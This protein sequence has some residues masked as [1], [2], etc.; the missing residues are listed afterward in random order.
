MI[1]A[2]FCFEENSVREISDII[3]FKKLQLQN[4]FLPHE[5]ENPE[6][7]KFLQY[8]KGFWEATF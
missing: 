2:W 5:N 3:V 8:K 1:L 7:S 4:V 6:F